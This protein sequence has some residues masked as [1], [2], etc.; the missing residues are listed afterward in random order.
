MEKKLQ[1]NRHKGDRWGWLSEDSSFLFVKLNRERL[2]LGQALL[3][4]GND[5]IIREC[6]DVA[7]FAMM[8]ADKARMEQ[9]R[10]VV[11]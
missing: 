3:L 9:S 10:A 1:E 11:L 4:S 8:I 7:N 6:A 5:E 2:E